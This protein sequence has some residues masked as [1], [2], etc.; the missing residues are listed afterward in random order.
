M[1]SASDVAV[2]KRLYVSRQLESVIK[3][4]YVSVITD[5]TLDSIVSTLNYVFLNS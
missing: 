5:R 1:V 4:A 2:D 3:S